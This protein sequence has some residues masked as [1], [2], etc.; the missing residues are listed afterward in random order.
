MLRS[1][2]IWLNV[3]AARKRGGWYEHCLVFVR[4]VLGIPSDNTPTAYQAWLNAKHKHNGIS[5]VKPWHPVYFGPTPH[6]AAGH[7]V[8]SGNCFNCK[9]YCWS[10][11]IGGTGTVTRHTYD[12]VQRWCGGGLLG[13][14]DDLDG[15]S[16]S[17]V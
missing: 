10:T 4:T 8:L 17:R 7:I 9:K 2:Q 11:D 3:L 14:S 13:W 15:K 12:E 16:V 1:A 5:D 6:N